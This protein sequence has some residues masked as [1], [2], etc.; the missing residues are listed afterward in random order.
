MEAVE[1]H[2]GSLTYVNPQDGVGR[3]FDGSGDFS[4]QR[5]DNDPTCR[6]LGKLRAIWPEQHFELDARGTF[7]Q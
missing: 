2:G 6:P 7:A 4:L 5:R 1:N 3:T